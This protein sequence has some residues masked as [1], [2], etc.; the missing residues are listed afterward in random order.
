MY[1]LIQ[2]SEQCYYLQSP[3]KI[4]LVRLNDADVCLID[5][6]SD[7]DAGRKVRQLLD[8]NGWRLTAIYNTHSN[9]DHIGGNHT[10]FV[11]FNG[12]QIDGDVRKVMNPLPIDE[13]F[14]AFGWHVQCID[15][16]DLE[17]I[18]QAV[19]NAENDGRPSVIICSTVKGKGISFM[20]NVADWHGK[21]PDEKQ[22]AVAR[23]E[24]YAA[25]MKAKEA[26]ENG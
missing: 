24:L 26:R 2:V 23:E 12:L 1:E 25:Y 5:S 20:E 17:Q 6:G 3:A 7:K 22:F 16:H 9:A 21:A 10:A 4:G 8:A 19:L 11:D 13:K 15:G 14:A 18:E